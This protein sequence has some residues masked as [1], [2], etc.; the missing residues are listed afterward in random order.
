MPP[1][2]TVSRRV[3]HTRQLEV[4]PAPRTRSYLADF[5]SIQQKQVTPASSCTVSIVWVILRLALARLQPAKAHWLKVYNDTAKKKKILTTNEL[6]LYGA[7]QY[8]ISL[9]SLKFRLQPVLNAVK[10][11]GNQ[12]HPSIHQ[13][14]CPYRDREC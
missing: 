12:S 11:S 4:V 3:N 9:V 10:V 8:I 7:A 5:S 13:T 1:D 6:Q 14:A 2:S